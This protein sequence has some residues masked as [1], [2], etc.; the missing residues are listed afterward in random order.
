MVVRDG[1]AGGGR[2]RVKR[3]VRRP[4]LLLVIL[5]ASSLGTQ[6]MREDEV[7]CEEAVA[8]LADCCQGFDITKV[9]CH[10]T[11]GCGESFP[12]LTPADSE[13]ILDKSCSEILAQDICKK[14]QDRAAAARPYSSN[15]AALAVEVCQ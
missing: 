9:D 10:Y 6:C 3:R 8:S 12:D 7:E 14:V 11:S 2:E 4:V 13:C 1:S 15:D 5:G